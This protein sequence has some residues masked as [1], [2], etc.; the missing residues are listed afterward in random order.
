MAL[1]TL[2]HMSLSPGEVF[3]AIH[4][5][6][7][8]QP[9]SGVVTSLGLHFSVRCVENLL[10]SNAKQLRARSFLSAFILLT[11]MFLFQKPNQNDLH[12]KF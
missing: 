7:P 2:S 3:T 9:I 10:N 4:L 1:C 11:Q 5:T 12:G 6:E 8:G